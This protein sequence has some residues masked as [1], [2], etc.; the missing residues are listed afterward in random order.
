MSGI[1]ENCPKKTI[2]NFSTLL[3]QLCGTYSFLEVVIYIITCAPMARWNENPDHI[4]FLFVEN[5]EKHLGSE[6]RKVNWNET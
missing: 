5:I 4:N 3:R 1:L 6:H 2:P